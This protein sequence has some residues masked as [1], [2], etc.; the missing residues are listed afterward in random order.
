MMMNSDTYTS[1]IQADF[2]QT[3]I[4]WHPARLFHYSINIYRNTAFTANFGALY[5]V[6]TPIFCPSTTTQH[7]LVSNGPSSCAPIF[8]F[9]T[10]QMQDSILK[11]AE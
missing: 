7:V 4:F 10:W 5:C 9:H 8:F 3:V 6:T 2:I 11:Q 1:T